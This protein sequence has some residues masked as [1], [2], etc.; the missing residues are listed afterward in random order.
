MDLARAKVEAAVV[1]GVNARE[2][3]ADVGHLDQEVI[4]DGCSL[5]RWASLDGE[6]CSVDPSSW[7]LR[8]AIPSGGRNLTDT[9]AAALTLAV[10]GPSV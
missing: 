6:P 8:D 5:A 7:K 1:E 10:P 9:V 4:H 3:L 2:A